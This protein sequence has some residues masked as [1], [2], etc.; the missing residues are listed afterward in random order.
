MQR[1]QKMIDPA[2]LV[3]LLSSR[4]MVERSKEE[5]R[6]L[7][8]NI[9]LQEMKLRILEEE[10]KRNI[11]AGHRVPRGWNVELVKVIGRLIP[12]WKAVHLEHMLK[13]HGQPIEMTIVQVREATNTP[14]IRHLQVVPPC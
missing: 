2:S 14:V 13:A 9:E 4:T 8:K 7:A 10:I 11:E 6:A 1:S 3:L 5:L 12:K